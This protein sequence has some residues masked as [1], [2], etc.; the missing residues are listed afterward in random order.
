MAP[1]SRKTLIA[2]PCKVLIGI[3][4]CFAINICSLQQGESFHPAFV[5]CSGEEAGRD[6]SR[7]RMSDMPITSM[8]QA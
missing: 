5:P 7:R 3:R 6:L 2:H 8:S 4:G 1:E